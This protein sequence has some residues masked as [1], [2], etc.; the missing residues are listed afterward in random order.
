M[1]VMLMIKNKDEGNTNDKDEGNTNDK[2]DGNADVDD[3]HLD[4]DTGGRAPRQLC[5]IAI[6]EH[7]TISKHCLFQRIAITAPIA[8]SNIALT[9]HIDIS[10]H[11]HIK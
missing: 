7:I 5:C 6:T 2:D 4:Q 8:M 3:G 11:C 10:K 9:A 1:H